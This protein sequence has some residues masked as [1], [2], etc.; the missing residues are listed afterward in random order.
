MSASHSTSFCLWHLAGTM[1]V[2]WL[3]AADHCDGEAF[4]LCWS[5]ATECYEFDTGKI[6]G[7]IQPYGW[8]H[9]V[10]GLVHRENRVDVV[11]PRNALLN[12]EY[13]LRPDSGPLM[14]PRELSSAKKITH[15]LVDGKVVLQFPPES[16]YAFSMQLAYRPHGDIIDMQMTIL[17]SKDVAD[18]EI[19]FAS[20]VTD[21]LSQTWVP[22]T[23]SDGSVQWKKLDNRGVRGRMFGIVRDREELRRLDD[24][25][26]GKT[27]S[28]PAHCE[29][30]DRFFHRPIFVARDPD[31]GVALVFLCDPR[32]TTFLAGQYHGWGTAHD[33]CY[34]ADLVASQPLVASTRLIY[35]RFANLSAMFRKI[36]REWPLFVTDAI[37][38]P[39]E[40]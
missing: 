33:W 14:K 6:F 2:A 9:G 31:N 5:D 27:L 26:W 28:D 10:A 16:D 15:R 40:E 21:A 7:V 36:D 24:G 22:L 19:F 12:A 29:L 39:E 37:G 1:F 18:F 23:G 11:R 32:Q 20:Y 8:Y 4:T 17:P 13:Y 25:R 34:S 35:R 3:L 38:D 30:E